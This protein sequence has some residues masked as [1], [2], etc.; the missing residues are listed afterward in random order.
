MGHGRQNPTAWVLDLSGKYPL[1][2]RLIALGQQIRRGKPQC[3]AASLA[4]RDAAGKMNAS[5]LHL[6]LAQ[7]AQGSQC[8]LFPPGEAKQ[9]FRR[10][11]N[12]ADFAR[13]R[14]N[15]MLDRLSMDKIN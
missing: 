4:S 8:P 11:K 13:P 6:R 9:G 14:T 12:R 3:S 1:R 7:N 5:A 15:W 2:Q 10:V